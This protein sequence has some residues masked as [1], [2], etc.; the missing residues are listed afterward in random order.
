MET[1]KTIAK[2]KSTREF[3]PDQISD[4]DLETILYA[5][6]MAPVAHGEYE[7]LHLTV[8]QDPD[9]LDML[10]DAAMDCFRDPI[11]DI[12]YGAPTV[13]IISTRHGSVPELDMANAGTIGQTMLLTATDLGLDSCY[14]WGTVLACRAET[15]LLEDLHIPEDYEPLASV[16]FGY[17]V[18]RD[19]TEKELTLEKFSMN[20]I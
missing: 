15:D 17:A 8:V 16:A 5:A 20:R 10:K 7:N 13:I 12:Y 9:I 2:R 14:I 18:E 6:N 19:D 11:R 1:L 3:K 4:K